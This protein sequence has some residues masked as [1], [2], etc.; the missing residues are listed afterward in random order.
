MS[1]VEG[2][3]SLPGMG[4]GAVEITLPNLHAKAADN[5]TLLFVRLVRLSA[6]SEKKHKVDCGASP[7]CL[8]NF[9][10]PCSDQSL[11]LSAAKI[12][13]DFAPYPY[14]PQG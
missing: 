7:V 9:V 8:A 3:V 2:I 14:R 5:Y 13:G 11:Y 12:F 1:L 4:F 6:R 10:A